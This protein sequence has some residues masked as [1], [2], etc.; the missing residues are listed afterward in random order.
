MNFIKR[1]SKGD[2]LLLELTTGQK[3]PVSTRKKDEFIKTISQ[4]IIN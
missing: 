4:K 1:L 2:E 3:L